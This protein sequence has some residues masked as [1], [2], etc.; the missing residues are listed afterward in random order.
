MGAPDAAVDLEPRRARR[1]RRGAALTLAAALVAVVAACTPMPPPPGQVANPSRSQVV[2]ADVGTDLVAN[3][4]DVP[5]TDGALLG[6]G[7]GASTQDPCGGSQTLDVYRHA[8]AAGSHRGTIVFVHGGG[9]VGGDKAIRDGLTGPVL[10]QVE[11]GWDVVSVNYRLNRDGSAPWPAALDDVEAAIRWI[12][13]HGPTVGIDPSR[14]VVAG[15][16]AGGT[17]AALAGV[18][19][20]TGDAAYAAV[21]RVDGWVDISGVNDFA[22]TATASLA[23]AWS[24]D[25]SLA[26]RMSPVS[27]IDSADPP[28]HIIHGDSDGIVAL[29]NAQALK[30]VAAQ[31]GAR[32]GLDVVDAWSDLTW[33]PSSVRNHLPTG[34]ANAAALDAFLDGI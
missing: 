29:V 23:R 21:A 27:A 30:L 25:R 31:R 5:Y 9:F 1:V 18:A 11:R 26:A 24:T 20:N 13:V 32:V 3:P 34:G 17:I 7:S 14:I 12:R 28:G 2:A 16:S 19:W 22:I 4:R 8:T 33:M 6:C 10:A 15:H